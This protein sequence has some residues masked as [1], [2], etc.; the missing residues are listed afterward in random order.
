MRKM[1]WIGRKKIAF[2]PVYRPHAA[3]P[4]VIP[5]DWNSDI[6]RRVLYDP[7][8]TT[9]L[10]RSLRAY[11][12]TA[13]SG[14]ADLEAVV[15]PMATIDIQD[16]KLSLLDG[17]LDGP[18]L[19]NQGFDAAA[20]VM[21]GG[22]GAGTSERGG[23]WARFVMAEKL[24]TW[25]MEL[26]HVLTGFADLYTLKGYVDYPLGDM[27]AFDEMACNCGTHPSAYTKAAINWLDAS[28]VAEHTG[29]TIGYEM[30]A[31]GLV[32]PPPFGRATAVRIGSEVPY[33]MVEA[34]LMVDQF[35]SPSQLEGGIPS[36]GVIVYRVQTPDPL[37]A[38]DSQTK[39]IPVFLLTPTALKVGESFTSDTN[40]SV[41]VTGTIPGGFSVVVED[42]NA[43][44]V[45]WHPW[46]RV[47]SGV[48]ALRSPITAI[49][50]NP[51]HLDLFV[52]GTDGGIYSTYWDASDG[53]HSWFRVSSGVA[54]LGS[55]VTAIS[56]NP[57]HIDLFITGTD[58]G[59]YTAWWDAS[60][61]W[62]PWSRVSNA[63]AAAGS[64]VTAISRNPDHIDLF[65][66]GTDGSIY[67][68]WWDASDGWHSWFSVS[69][70]A[71]AA[72]SPITAISRNPNHLDLF[73]TG[74]DGGIYSTWWD[75]SDGWHSWFSVSGGAA[76][77]QSPI[78]AIS[79]NPD[80]LDLFVTATDGGIYSTWWDA[81]DGWH[82]WFRVS[83]AAA[84]LG[85]LVTAIFRN[86]DHLDLFV[87]GTDGN[88]YSTWWD[89]SD[90]WHSWFTVSNGVAAA[91][92][93][94]T[95]IARNPNHLDLFVTR[96]DGGIYSTWWDSSE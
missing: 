9:Q 76:A 77:L 7:D 6:L 19:R 57:D 18:G 91:G 82:L 61:G 11:I 52:T 1:T 30:H 47:T 89:A 41:S 20:I 32:Q 90:G 4:D 58:G 37:G 28:S 65:V 16:L 25:A 36:Q 63:V 87:T 13:S 22:P 5:S 24:G 12:H 40:V 10:D 88:I 85:S 93:P 56:R 78:T 15:M 50:R 23:F 84:P 39:L 8:K 60:D 43:P 67:S 95:A 71:A 17:L 26:M 48:A 44:L 29:R 81:S 96:T 66:T 83:N 74:T 14:R 64:L 79:R 72:G 31:V 33:L 35:E 42:R 21:L 62:H 27:G 51:N 75:A 70:G 55:P 69:G 34:R 94:I 68:T 49:S 38:G 45:G 46:F 3:P 53:W 59:I 80:H 54:A 2:I 92:S 73:V 86:P